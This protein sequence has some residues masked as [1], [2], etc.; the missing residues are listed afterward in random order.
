MK[1][2]LDS[3]EILV[4]EEYDRA[5]DKFGPVNH[6]DHESFA[7]ILEECEEADFEFDNFSS[8]LK[9]F[10]SMVK[11]KDASAKDKLRV[12]S[13]MQDYAELAACELIQIC[14][15]CAKAR[16]TILEREGEEL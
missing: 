14:A 11:D 3:V 16:R 7:I 5:A 9:L 6:S 12:L 13:K 8:E 4:E 10:W 1:E 2:L 15:M